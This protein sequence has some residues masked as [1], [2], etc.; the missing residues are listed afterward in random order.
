MPFSFAYWLAV[1][2]LRLNA[3]VLSITAPSSGRSFQAEPVNG[4]DAAIHYL[5]LP[6]FHQERDYEQAASSHLH[7]ADLSLGLARGARFLLGI[8]QY[9]MVSVRLVSSAR[10]YLVCFSSPRLVALIDTNCDSSGP[11]LLRASKQD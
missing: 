3:R 2:G 11:A 4:D 9:T 8:P 5:W 1:S 10:C 6:R 7:S